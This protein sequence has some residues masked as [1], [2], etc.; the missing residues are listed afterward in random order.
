MNTGMWQVLLLL[1]LDGVKSKK[2]NLGYSE[3]SKPEL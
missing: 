3:A 2:E 1:H